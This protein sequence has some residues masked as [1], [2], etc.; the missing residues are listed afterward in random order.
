MGFSRSQRVRLKIVALV[1]PAAAIGWMLWLRLAEDKITDQKLLQEAVAEWKNAGEPGNGPDCQI[2]EQLAAQGY[3]D[4]A[5]ATAHRF[6]RAEDVRWSVVELTKI[7]AENGDI[8]GANNAIA[9]LVGSDLGM[10]AIEVIA[11]TQVHN[12]DL[13]AA[14]ETIG[15]LGNADEVYLAYGSHQIEMGDFEGTLETVARMGAK[16]GYQLFYDI[17]DAL[18]RR[19]EQSRARKLAAHMKDPKLAALFLE[20]A[21]FTLWHREACEVRVIQPTPCDY[22]YMYAAEG[23]FAEADALIQ[24]NKCSNVSYVAAQQYAVDP[25]GAEHLLRTRADRDDLARGL[26]ELAKA[27]AQKR[28]ISEALRFLD[29][30][31]DLSPAHTGKNDLREV[32]RAWTIRDGPKAVFKWARSRPTTEQRTWALIGMAEALGHSRPRI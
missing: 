17:G 13:A 14:L 9:N 4:D 23:K 12:G 22:S 31:Q 18:R 16:A 30:L 7:R 26:S 32:A 28:D 29:E 5:T 19:G 2:F 20:C 24:K 21:R 1:L 10:K 6:K 11:L 15:P 8:R 3:Y 27:A 25:V